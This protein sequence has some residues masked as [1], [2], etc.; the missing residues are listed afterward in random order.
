VTVTH[1]PSLGIALTLE[2]KA[3]HLR[4]TIWREWRPSIWVPLDSPLRT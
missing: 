4:I 2:G 3:P 1:V